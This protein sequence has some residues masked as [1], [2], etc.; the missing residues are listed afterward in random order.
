MIM[1][2]KNDIFSEH[3]G[4]YIKADKQS[5]GRILDHVCFVT[6]G[7]RKAA[8]RKFRKLWLHGQKYDDQRGKSEY[9]GPDVTVALKAV[10]QAGN[11]ACGELLHPLISEYVSILKRDL[12]WAYGDTTTAKLLRMSMSTV[13]RRIDKF[14]KIKKKRKGIASTKPSAIKHLVPVFIGPWK[15]KEPGYGQI[16]T[17]RHSNTAS[18]DAV[19][20]V[21]YTDAA[22]LTAVL[23]AQWNKGQLAT[24]TSMQSIKERLPF[25]WQGAHPDTGSEFLNYIVMKWCQEEKIELSRSR[26]SH[27][28]DN[29]Y[30]EERN[31]HA[32][33][34]TIGYITLN[35]PQSV[36]ALNSV[37]DVLNPYLLHFLAVRRLVKKERLSS[38]YQRTYEKIAKTPYRRILEHP[39]VPDE[40]KNKLREEHGKL[41]PLILKQEIDRRLKTLYDTQR[42][43]GN[44]L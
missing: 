33:R 35:C 2:T 6:G 17:V 13:K 37:Y 19:Y 12:M 36:K 34:K 28:N 25:L 16:D 26:P 9:Y 11:E 39:A 31:G 14:Q 40:A 32:V 10:W 42:R 29:M 43:F 27:K 7:H 24:R 41:N 20:T 21:N 5:K 44:H 1:E 3:L 30:V 18:G 15:G 38:R 4:S 8:I 23:R 22:T